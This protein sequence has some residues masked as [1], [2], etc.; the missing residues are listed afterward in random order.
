[1][2][3]SLCSSI[4]FYLDMDVYLEVGM[5]DH[6]PRVVLSWMFSTPPIQWLNYLFK[7]CWITHLFKSGVLE[8]SNSTI[9]YIIYLKYGKFPGKQD[10]LIHSALNIHKSKNKIKIIHFSWILKTQLDGY[11]CHVWALCLASKGQMPSTSVKTRNNTFLSTATKTTELF[12]VFP[13]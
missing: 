9:C 13:I 5:S 1:M 7:F 12:M 2:K 10:N 6:G 4:F 11:F 8:E 3:S